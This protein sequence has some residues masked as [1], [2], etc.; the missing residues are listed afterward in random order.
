MTVVALI[1]RWIS[2]NYYFDEK[3]N[4][5]NVD[6]CTASVLS[7]CQGHRIVAEILNISKTSDGCSANT[8]NVW[9]NRSF[10]I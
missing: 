6:K 10:K 5:S 3:N 7:K 2:D 4:R 1:R 9:R 8:E